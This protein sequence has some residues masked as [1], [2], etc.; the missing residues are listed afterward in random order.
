MEKII[1]SV[2]RALFLTWCKL[3]NQRSGTAGAFSCGAAV[4][5]LGKAD[6]FPAHP[7]LF[8]FW[9]GYFRA[10]ISR[11]RHP[12]RLIEIAVINFSLPIDTDQGAAHD[13]TRRFGIEAASQQ[14]QIF[15]IGAIG[16]EMFPKTP[17]R[18]VRN[19]EKMVEGDPVAG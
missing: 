13:T 19:S 15:G 6:F 2:D 8:Q 7:L 9:N 17:D 16:F 5:V 18:C 4:T 10:I 11:N 12:Q 1:W 3:P 14:A